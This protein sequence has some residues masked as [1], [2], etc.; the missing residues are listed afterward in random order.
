MVVWA[1]VIGAMVD[2]PGFWVLLLLLLLLFLL[3]FYFIFNHVSF[4]SCV[5]LRL[6]VQWL[7][8][9]IGGTRHSWSGVTNGCELLMWV[10][11]TESQK[12]I[13]AACFYLYHFSGPLL[14]FC[15]ILFLFLSLYSPGFSLC[16]LLCLHLGWYCHCTL[17]L[18]WPWIFGL[19]GEIAY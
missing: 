6:W 15:F 2:H 14:G 5:D 13:R 19:V 11:G 4:C 16:W 18:T 8:R 17:L 12:S 7:L 3:R 9:P 10:L 1:P